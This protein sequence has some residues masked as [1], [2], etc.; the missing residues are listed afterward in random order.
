[1]T[2]SDASSLPKLS[3]S[4]LVDAIG[5]ELAKQKEQGQRDVKKVHTLMEQY[6]ASLN[7]WKRYA[8]FDETRSYTRN[9]IATDNE[10]FTLMLLCWNKAKSSP[11]HDHANSE[12][13]LRVVDGVAHENLYE[14]TGD[15]EELKCMKSSN[16]AAGTV[17]YIH[18]TIG[19]HS[20][21]NASSDENMVSLHCYS[22]PFS[23]CHVFLEGTGHGVE[24]NV[25]F[26]SEHGQVVGLH[27]GSSAIT[28]I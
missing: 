19:L 21:G 18:D 5:K 28:D 14:L 6:D 27:H 26:Y 25:T 15:D 12:C 24:A 2:M 13:W 3:M 1:M 16:A 4:E 9:L 7:E 20:I 23:Q 11:I 22:P 8:H 10:N 17:C